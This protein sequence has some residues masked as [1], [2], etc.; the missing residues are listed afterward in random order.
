MSRSGSLLP[1]AGDGGPPPAAKRHSDSGGVSL[2]ALGFA[3]VVLA[4]VLVGV[5]ATQLHL[6]RLRLAHV[7]DELALDAADAMDLGAY[8]AG[9]APIPSGDAAIE[10]DVSIARAVVERRAAAVA[11]RHGLS[12]VVVLDVSVSDGSTVTVVV[13]VTVAPALD[14]SGVIPWTDGVALTSTGTARVH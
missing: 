5:S 13:G 9:S 3:L 11:A 12:G 7:A 14:L 1:V 2:L 10:V 4:L 8:Y 6:D